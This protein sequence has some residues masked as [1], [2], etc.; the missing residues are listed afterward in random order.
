MACAR[1]A[2]LDPKI[3]AMLRLR[4][5]VERKIDDLSHSS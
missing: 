5:K 4:C 1:A 3:I 2:R